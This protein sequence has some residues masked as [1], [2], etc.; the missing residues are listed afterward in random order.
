[1]GGRE[2]RLLSSGIAMGG[3]KLLWGGQEDKGT[4][5]FQWRR[6]TRRRCLRRGSLCFFHS[7]GRWEMLHL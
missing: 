5:T 1:M 3:P 7:I 2:M 4:T 6:V